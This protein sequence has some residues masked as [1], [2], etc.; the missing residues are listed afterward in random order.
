MN[1]ELIVAASTHEGEEEEFSLFN[2]LKSE[3]YNF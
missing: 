3:F 1:K 2:K